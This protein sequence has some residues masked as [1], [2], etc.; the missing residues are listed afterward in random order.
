MIKL[1]I[2]EDQKVVQ[3]LLKHC[4]ANYSDVEIV[5]IVNDGKSGVE[6]AELLE[7]DV[8]IMD[9]EMPEMDGF[10]ASKIILE[11][12]PNANILIFSLHEELKFIDRAMALG[13]KGYLLKTASPK[14]MIDAIR[15]AS[16]GK[17][18]KL[19]AAAINTS[20]IIPSSSDSNGKFS[21]LSPQNAGDISDYR[22]IKSI[23]SVEKNIETI[24][25]D[26]SLF[27]KRIQRLDKNTKYYQK[28]IL[29][30]IALSTLLTVALIVAILMLV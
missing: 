8:I 18:I 2:V 12:N 6:Q 17:V 26:I 20:D 21:S 22:Q 10:E 24:E 23:E 16:E 1:L 14:E 3:H 4:F 15:S 28:V 25:Q 30:L 9:I 11:K 27:R 29:Y 13:V 7:P 5:N 19:K